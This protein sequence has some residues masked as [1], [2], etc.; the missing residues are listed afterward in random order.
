MVAASNAVFQWMTGEAHLELPAEPY[1][2]A[3][4]EVLPVVARHAFTD[5]E[6]AS[7]NAQRDTPDF[8]RGLGIVEVEAALEKVADRLVDVSTGRVWAWPLARLIRL[9]DA[10]GL[11]AEVDVVLNTLGPGAAT[12]VRSASLVPGE[13]P[14]DENFLELVGR[15]G[16]RLAKVFVERLS[17]ADQRR[18]ALASGHEVLVRWNA[19]NGALV[20]FGLG[21]QVMAIARGEPT[22]ATP[23]AFCES[24]KLPS[25]QPGGE[26]HGALARYRKAFDEAVQSLSPHTIARQI[27]RG[28]P[29]SGCP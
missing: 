20:R 24:V 3:L 9:A 26:L 29:G 22:P 23:E 2:T 27:V 11:G 16:E 8:R 19:V 13:T 1:S 7:W 18:Y 15:S 5:G 17:P 21:P 25:C 10:H 12:R 6:L 28:L 14:P 4:R